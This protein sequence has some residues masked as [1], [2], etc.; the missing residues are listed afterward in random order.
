MNAEV[1]KQ[2]AQMTLLHTIR[3]AAVAI[4]GA[5]EKGADI[6][7]VA[8]RVKK[9]SDDNVEYEI[10]ASILIRTCFAGVHADALVDDVV[11]CMDA[12]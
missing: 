5:I 10:L 1:A 7:A 6:S 2:M 12:P 3:T 11:D 8:N 4:R 9:V